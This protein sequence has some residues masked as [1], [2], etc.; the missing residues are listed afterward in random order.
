MM[1]PKPKRAVL[2]AG[3]LKFTW[4][5]NVMDA[6]L[7]WLSVAVHVTVVFPSGNKVPDIG[8]HVATPAPSTISVV[9]GDEYGTFAPDALWLV[10]RIFAIGEITGGVVS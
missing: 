1:P 8:E 7:P 9:V 10:T 6:V 2:L 3:G 5:T 4:T